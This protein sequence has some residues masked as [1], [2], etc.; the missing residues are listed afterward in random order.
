MNVELLSFQHDHKL[1][2]EAAR[3][4][5]IVWDRDPEDSQIFFRK[6]ARFPHFRGYIARINGITVGTIFGTASLPGQWWHDKV[7]EQVGEQHPALQDAWVLTELAVLE[8]YRSRGIGGLLHDHVLR[9][10]PLKTAL[11]STQADNSGAQRFYRQ[12]GWSYLHSGFPFHPGR[13]PYVIMMRWL[14]DA[15]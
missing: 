8:A 15:A 6:Y 2:R 14:H 4:Y 9:D 12:R 10:L 11:L 13:P 7:A 5:Q 3:I 1:L